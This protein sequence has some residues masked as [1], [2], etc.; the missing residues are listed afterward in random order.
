MIK[1]TFIVE[2]H[3]EY[4]SVGFRPSWV[5]NADPLGGMAVAHDILEH[6][7][8]DDGGV[9]CELMALGAAMWIRGKGGWW[10]DAY[11]ADPAYHISGDFEELYRHVRWE[12][13]SLRDSGRTRPLNDEEAED[14]CQRAATMGLRSVHENEGYGDLGE[15]EESHL[16]VFCSEQTR[17]RVVG[18]L[19]RGYR[20]AARRY[21]N[22]DSYSLCQI[23]RTIQKTAD[24]W[25]ERGAEE[26]QILEVSINLRSDDLKMKGGYPPDPYMDDYYGPET[27]TLIY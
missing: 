5:P 15:E 20:K 24:K 3:E 13:F 22:S 21:R 11:H 18:W 19:R 17:Q 23:F 27:L 7:P 25:L 8:G 9:E 12:N 1:R 10:H 14:W 2:E 4:G 16:S 26:Q 6:F